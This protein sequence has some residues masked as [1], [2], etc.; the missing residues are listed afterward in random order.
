MQFEFTTEQ[1]AN[2]AI[3]AIHANGGEAKVNTTGTGNNKR[4]KVSVLKSETSGESTV[5]ELPEEVQIT[6]TVRGVPL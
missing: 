1:R 5:A 4:W 3:E 6:N 2:D